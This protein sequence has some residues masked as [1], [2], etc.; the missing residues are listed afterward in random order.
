MQNGTDKECMATILLNVVSDVKLRLLQL[1]CVTLT[2]VECIKI[3][4]DAMLLI[5]NMFILS[6]WEYLD[7]T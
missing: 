4:F 5:I 1:C 3:T 7:F 2:C 6:V